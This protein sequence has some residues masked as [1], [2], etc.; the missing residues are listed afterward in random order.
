M[1]RDTFPDDYTK[2]YGEG[3]RENMG[4]FDKMKDFLGLSGEPEAYAQEEEQDYPESEEAS[5][6]EEESAAEQSTG[7]E[8]R[9]RVMNLSTVAQ[10]KVVLVRPKRFEDARAAA[11]QLNAKCTVVLNLESVDS[12]TAH[13]IL[14][15]LAGAAYANKG[16]IRPVSKSTFIITPHNVSIEDNSQEGMEG[17]GLYF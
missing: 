3:G 4:K 10:Q 8:P 6:Q 2:D 9:A 7:F 5:E 1:S 14:D 11:D 13:H 12:E 15:F 17:S 16:N